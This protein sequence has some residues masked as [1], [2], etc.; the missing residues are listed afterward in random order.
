MFLAVT[1]CVAAT[2]ALR[3]N[4]TTEDTDKSKSSKRLK[5]AFLWWLIA[6]L[7]GGFAV[8][9]RPDS[10]LFVAAIGLTLVLTGILRIWSAPAERSGDGAFDVP[11]SETPIQSGVALRLPP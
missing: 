3:K 11:L 8:L 2:M 10:G 9:I 1:M 4:F 6:G 5:Q 7:L